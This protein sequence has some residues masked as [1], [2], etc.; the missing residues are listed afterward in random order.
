MG[1]GILVV[2][3]KEQVQAAQGILDTESFVVGE[4]I[5]GKTGVTINGGS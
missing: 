1:I 4:I 2:L 5:S 3:P